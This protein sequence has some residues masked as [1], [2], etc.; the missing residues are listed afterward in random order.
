M[1]KRIGIAA[2]PS[3]A[4][5][6]AVDDAAII[7]LTKENIVKLCQLMPARRRSPF[8]QRLRTFQLNLFKREIYSS[9]RPEG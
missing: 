3:T 4:L 7:P 2:V 6:K 9:I 5:V 8:L 1:T